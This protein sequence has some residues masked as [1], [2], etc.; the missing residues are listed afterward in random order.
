M[1][2]LTVPL[3]LVLVLS[4]TTTGR[5]DVIFLDSTAAEV[6]TRRHSL[7]L[8]AR[9]RSGYALLRLLEA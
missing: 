6:L 7:T 9:L 2:Y 8:E 3:T 5:L 1:M 4:Q